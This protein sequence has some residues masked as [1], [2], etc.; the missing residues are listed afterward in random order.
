MLTRDQAERNSL[1]LLKKTD[2]GYRSESCS[3]TIS[4]H[5]N[6]RVSEVCAVPLLWILLQLSAGNKMAS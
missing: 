3:D 1:N 5:H 2:A 6:M 4:G